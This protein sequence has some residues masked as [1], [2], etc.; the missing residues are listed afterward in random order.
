VRIGG[1][2]ME[3]WLNEVCDTHQTKGRI[4]GKKG[5]IMLVLQ[6]VWAPGPQLQKEE[7]RKERDHYSPK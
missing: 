7:R 4:R 3:I 2:L 6:K 5:E 1:E